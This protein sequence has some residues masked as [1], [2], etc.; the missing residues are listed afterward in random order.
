MT[1]EVL[2]ARAAQSAAFLKLCACGL[3]VG[4]ALQCSGWLHG[5]RQWLGNVWDAVWVTLLLIG[6]FAIMLFSGEGV[7]LYALVGLALGAAIYGMGVRVVV[8]ALAK[9]LGALFGKRRGD[10]EHFAHK[11]KCAQGRKNGNER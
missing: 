9:H 1:L 5:R 7:R 8:S 3:M 4:A 11:K 10:A 2:F 6:V